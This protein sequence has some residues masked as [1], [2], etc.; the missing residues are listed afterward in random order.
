[1]AQDPPTGMPTPV[2]PAWA[3]ASRRRLGRANRSP[4]GSRSSPT[5]V[6]ATHPLR[7]RSLVALVAL[8]ARPGHHRPN[9]VAA[10]ADAP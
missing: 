2:M 7:E 3:G 5:A 6:A 8:D 1:M 4:Y 10:G 9:R